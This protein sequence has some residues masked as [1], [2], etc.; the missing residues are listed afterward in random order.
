MDINEY[1][2]YASKIDSFYESSLKC[3]FNEC[4]KSASGLN[5]LTENTLNRN[6]DYYLESD[7]SDAVTNVYNKAYNIIHAYINKR[8]DLFNLYKRKRD[9]E[10]SYA[11]LQSMAKDKNF[12]G[13]SFYIFLYNVDD[14]NT[15]D[16]DELFYNYILN[17]T[18]YISANNDYYKNPNKKNEKRV[19]DYHVLYSHLSQTGYNKYI[20]EMKIETAASLIPSLISSTNLSIIELKKESISDYIKA[21]PNED[22][23][24]L[25]TKI[26]NKIKSFIDKRLYIAALNIEM[27]KYECNCIVEKI[28]DKKAKDYVLTGGYTSDELD[29]IEK[30]SKCI[31]TIKYGKN[32]YRILKTPIPHMG[33]YN[34]YGMT[35]FVQDDFLKLPKAMQI[36]TLAHEIGHGESWHFSDIDANNK[37]KASDEKEA[38]KLVAEDI[39]YFE[40]KF[41]HKIGLNDDDDKYMDYLLYLI[42]E[43][44]ADRFSI[45]AAGKWVYKKEMYLTL[46][47]ALNHDK[48]LRGMSKA[49]KRDVMKYNK[50]K[51]N[52]RIDRF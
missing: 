12:S 45:S 25:I 50:K 26:F 6:K 2:E 37:R 4:N 29:K 48:R 27:I 13:E 24:L 35:I 21:H 9:L 52:L 39:R 47:D 15:E 18:R 1:F 38:L 10:K 20:T 17:Y 40:K 36:A 42:S 19:R 34:M 28:I 3:I 11:C 46:F 30:E 51:L 41:H 23:K 16:N 7:I 8:I 44:E 32:S 33:A 5:H 43:W 22:R 49:E 31:G 14:K